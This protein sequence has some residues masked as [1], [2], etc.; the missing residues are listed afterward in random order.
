[1]AECSEKVEKYLG[2]INKQ[3][4]ECYDIANEAKSKGFDP[5]KRV[6]MPLA[7]NMA[8]RV[9]GLIGAVAPEILGK[10][11]PKRI[12]ELE[13]EYG[14]QDWRVALKIAEEVARGDFCE[15]EDKVRAMEVGI[16]TGFAYVTVGVVASPLEG[17]ICLKLR[18]RMDGK[19]KY[20]ALVYGGP[21]RSAGGTGAS[22]SIL[23]ADYVRKKM[24]YEEYDATEREVKRAY[25]ELCDYHERVTNLQYFP[26]EEEVK[27]LV[28]H[29]P[30]Q[31]D[32]DPSEKW[33]VSNYKDLSRRI[34]NRIS[35]G[36]CLITAEC[37]GLKAPKV[38]KQ[39]AIW[40]KDFGMEQWNF[41]KDFVDLQKEIRARGV[42]VDKAVK[43]K[44]K[45]DTNYIKD[46]VA[47]RPVFTHP[48]R[49]GGFRLR[50]GRCRVSGFSADAVNPATMVA[51]D[52]FIAVGT[53]FKVERPGKATVVNV[54]DSIDGPIVRLKNGSVVALNDFEKAKLVVKEID[55]IIYLGD[56]LV[57]YGDFLDRAHKLVPAGF[58]EEWWAMIV[59]K[60]FLEKGS[61]GIEGVEKV[62][63]FPLKNR[64]GFD[65]ALEY[66]KKLGVP[67]YP[68]YIYYWKSIS[69]DDF[70]KLYSVLKTCPFDDGRMVVGDL[71]VK[72]SLELIGC[73][74][75]LV[76][77]EHLVI[78]DA[79]ALVF[80]LGGFS[81]ELVEK[82]DVLEMVN[83]LCEFE[84]K[85]KCGTFVGARMGR[86]EKAKMRKMKGSPHVLFSVGEEGG[87]LRCFQSA[88]E[89]GKITA[90]FPVYDC[91][92]G[93][94]TIYAVCENCGKRTKQMFYCRGCKKYYD[95]EE[96]EKH[97]K[98][99]KAVRQELDIKHYF[100]KALEVM[101]SRQYPSLI[102]GVRGM[103]S[104][105]KIPEHLLR[106][107]LR[108]KHR[109]HV[110]KDGTIRYDMI[111]LPLT[112]FKAKEIGTSV[113]RLKELGYLKDVY[114]RDLVSDDQVL[115]LMAQ[116]VVLPA[117]IDVPEEGADEILFRAT[118]FMDDL[119]EN[120]YKMPKFYD[121]EKKKDLVG[122]L[123]VAMSPHTSAGIVSRII[124][125][126]KCQ[127]LYAHPLLHSIMRRDCVHPNTEL[128]IGRKGKKEL[129]NIGEYVE[130]LIKRGAKTKRIDMVGTLS[131]ENID[132]VCVYGV[133]SKTFEFKEKKVKSFIRGPVNNDWV[134][135]NSEKG[136]KFVMT[137]DHNHLS[138]TKKSFE[139]IKAK[140]VSVGDKLVVL[141]DNE[142]LSEKI[143]KVDRL[144]DLVNSY[145]LDVYAEEL[146]EKNV[147]WGDDI[148]NLRCDGDEAGCMLL[149]DCLLN[150]SKKFLPNTRGISQDAP[151]VLTGRLVPSEVDD[152][153]FNMDVVDHYPLELYEAAEQFKFPWDIKIEIFEHNLNTEKQYEGMM[154][155]HDTDDFNK[156][157]ICS[158]Y[159]TLPSMREKVLGQ[160]E[161]GRK[162]R[163]VDVDDVARLV[164]E[165]HFIRDI[166]GNLRKFS[167]QRFR[168]VKCNTVYRRPPLSGKCIGCSGKLVF[169]IAEGSVC[170]YLQPALDLAKKYDLPAYLQQSLVLLKN[171]IESVFGKDSEKQE[172][173]GKWF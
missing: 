121:L 169:T 87:R 85:D 141:N 5:N 80:N 112:H 106:G 49:N 6:M 76:G 29:L 60:N 142:V 168:C 158:A 86:P 58:V 50:Y 59:K 107:I 32:G 143:V 129:V 54:C 167:Q 78:E 96:C 114:G 57:N 89:V 48:M 140:D 159:K 136:K 7:K 104:V 99:M 84:I 40:G 75:K 156:G 65:S 26:S 62:I 38:W 94:R 47:G 63:K 67:L 23:I 111:E 90:E 165:R 64:L 35:N 27:Y 119:L 131:V 146:V 123:I 133:D 21:I 120:L 77:D 14:M 33:D 109:V 83:C 160:M 31:L 93:N 97:D 155:T 149:M 110:N 13:K 22:V 98:N 163:A 61:Q 9:E 1:M 126:S 8:E 72:Q 113:E 115:E 3:V 128:V 166:K 117:P 66:S 11:V 45:A 154:F 116:D 2:D 42:K 70:K 82:E 24:G 134:V 71:S 17:F 103:S 43:E 28:E 147:L 145:C 39:L 56:L 88:L 4:L 30:I 161:V 108:A 53:Q 55:E 162:I 10:G 102:K 15:F 20:M 46:L 122:H 79:H 130:G 25:S 125:F 118:K 144:V 139:I 68:K 157:V 44:I 172:G 41:M 135:V 127:G 91:E 52:D 137:P 105:E 19:G 81:K 124:G 92:C 148:I 138:L 101:G 151:L 36:F 150:F 73:E 12:G 69:V 34:D 171:R 132:S 16:R 152:M 18:D 173:L 170:K 153:V 37:L 95:T 100:Y 74:H 164:I 51:S